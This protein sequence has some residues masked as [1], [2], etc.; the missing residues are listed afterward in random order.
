ME[1]FANKI[2]EFIAKINE[3]NKENKDHNDDDMD[4]KILKYQK[5]KV[6]NWNENE[7]TP[8]QEIND[9]LLLLEKTFHNEKTNH[10]WSNWL[11][12]RVHFFILKQ[13]NISEK[14]DEKEIYQV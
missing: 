3:K 7:N 8:E 10:I 4:S 14:I 1:L 9:T 6:P 11:M 2:K 12:G 13:K 5:I